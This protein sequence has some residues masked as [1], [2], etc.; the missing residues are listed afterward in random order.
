MDPPTW[1][2]LLRISRG[3]LHGL[4]LSHLMLREVYLQGVQMQDTNLR[5]SRIQSS[6]FTESFD[7]MWDV[8][9]S[10]NGKY[11]AAVSRRGEIRVWDSAR[12][13]S[14]QYVAGAWRIWRNSQLQSRQSYIGEW[15]HG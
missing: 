1:Q 15:E 3:D 14:A 9:I 12:T 7:S 6:I 10:P 2:R 5:D 8:A 4:D 11:W 13:D